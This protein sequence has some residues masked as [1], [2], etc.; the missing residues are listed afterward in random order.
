MAT[1]PSKRQREEELTVQDIKSK[2]RFFFSRD[3]YKE[4]A[5][6][7]ED[8][9]FR[10][11]FGCSHVVILRLW[12]LLNEYDL[13]PEGGRLIHLFWALLFVKVYPT[14]ETL[15]T[16]C[17]DADRKTLRKWIRRFMQAISFLS[18]EVVSVSSI[19]VG[20]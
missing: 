15:T 7:T 4:R 12:N 20:W 16:L 9:K 18:S 1:I 13:V 11:L 19:I 17:G 3:P 14:E 10:A 5:P 6:K 8:K 2:A